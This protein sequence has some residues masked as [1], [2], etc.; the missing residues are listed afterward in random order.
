MNWFI[1]SPKP[2][3]RAAV[4]PAFGSKVIT[5]DEPEV[6]WAGAGNERSQPDFSLSSALAVI[7]SYRLAI[8]DA[9]S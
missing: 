8:F 3:V 4:G 1:A 6:F 7:S 2:D 9:T 5:P